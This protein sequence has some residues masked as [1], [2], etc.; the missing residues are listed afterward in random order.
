[1]SEQ[2]VREVLAEVWGWI[3]NWDPNFIHDDEWPAT[4]AKVQTVLAEYRSETGE[5]LHELRSTPRPSQ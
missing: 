4:A 5:L 1:M 2:K 3:T